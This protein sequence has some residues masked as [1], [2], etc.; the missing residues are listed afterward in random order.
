MAV[1]DPCSVPTH[2]L[3]LSSASLSPPT[4]S[5]SPLP[6]PHHTRCGACWCLFVQCTHNAPLDS[7]A[8]DARCRIASLSPTTPQLVTECPLTLRQ[9]QPQPH[10]RGE[11]DCSDLAACHVVS[12]VTTLLVGSTRHRHLRSLHVSM[13]SR[14]SIDD[15]RPPSESVPCHKPTLAVV[16]ALSIFLPFS[17]NDSTTESDMSIAGVLSS[18]ITMLLKLNMNYGEQCESVEILRKM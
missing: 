18:P 10:S 16:C 6:L 4:P 3:P 14:D 12:A 15:C 7:T 17:N 11:Q 8:D 1:L 2:T 5:H 9:S 13:Q